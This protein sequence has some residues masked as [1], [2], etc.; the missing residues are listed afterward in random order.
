VLL[1]APTEEHRSYWPRSFTPDGRSLLLEMTGPDAFYL[2]PI[3]GGEP[4]LLAEGSAPQCSPDGRMIV[5]HVL[6]YLPDRITAQV[7]L[8][9]LRAGTKRLLGDGFTPEFNRDG[10]AVY[11]LDQ[12]P[13]DDNATPKLRILPLDGGAPHSA[14]ADTHVC[15]EHFS[16]DGRSLAYLKL[17]APGAGLYLARAD[18]SRARHIARGTKVSTAQF[19]PDG[20]H[21]VY[22]SGSAWSVRA[23]AGRHAVKTM[24]DNTPSYYLGGVQFT[25]DGRQLLYVDR[26]ESPIGHPDED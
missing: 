1:S 23:T 5:Y 13:E 9:D 21:F 10:T 15:F 17:H 3:T 8:L 26:P 12:H 6:H 16:P 11:C 22:R 2:L 18:G 14:L 19:S 25:P 7:M 24:W 4:R 20:S